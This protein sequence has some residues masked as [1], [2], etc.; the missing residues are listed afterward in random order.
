[1]QP[2][3][4]KRSEQMVAGSRPAM[5]IEDILTGKGHLQKQ[6]L[7]EREQRVQQRDKALSSVSKVKHHCFTLAVMFWICVIL[8]IVHIV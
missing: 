6:R 7:A 2:K 3:L 5:P 8:Y 1:M 4:N